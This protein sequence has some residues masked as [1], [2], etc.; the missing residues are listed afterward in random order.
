LPP[1]RIVDALARHALA[2]LHQGGQRR[3]TGTLGELMRI[4]VVGA[5]GDGDLGIAHL[6][7]PVGT[8]RITSRFGI[9][10]AHA[11]PSAMVSALL[12]ATTLPAA[13]RA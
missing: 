5:H 12:V 13:R 6:H 1:L 7:D 8:F 4:F 9:R 2:L 10:S 3:R 11:I